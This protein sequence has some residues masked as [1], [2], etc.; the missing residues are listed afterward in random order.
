[1]PSSNLQRANQVKTE[2]RRL[3]FDFCGISKADFLEEEAPRLEKWIQ[4]GK[5]G[6]MKWM[7]NHF[8]MRLDPR[9]LVDGAKSVISVL[10]NYSTNQAQS[11][12]SAKVSQYA[13]GEDYHYVVRR[14]LKQL[15]EFIRENIGDTYGRGFVDS[16]PILDK[17][18]AARSGLGWI[19]KHTN[20]INKDRGSYFFVGELI[21]DME[22]SYDSPVGDYCGTC[23]AC[24]DACPTDAIVRPY[25][26]DGSRCISYL[27]IEL[28]DNIP[29]EFKGKM[30]DWIFGCDVCQQVCPWNR[31]ATDHN[32]PEF[33]PHPDLLQLTW[34][35]WEELTEE[36]YKQLFPKSA[37][38]RAKYE[39]LKRNIA[40]AKK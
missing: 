25:E 11:S 6:Q 30:D 1:M 15:L 12:G 36:S 26:V 14:K 23:T 27:T 5:H 24:I 31:F 19:G 13:W 21:V 32:V 9:K 4:A 16:A 29:H 17:A 3:G 35:D 22:F 37:V 10:L 34:Q 39:G 18:W 28:R 2:A 20:L 8:D 38:K 40:F 33:S 7:E